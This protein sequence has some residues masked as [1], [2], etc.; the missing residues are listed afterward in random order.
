MILPEAASGLNTRATRTSIN[1]DLPQRLV[2]L[3]MFRKVEILTA[4]LAD[5][6]AAVEAACAEALA[7]GVCSADVVLNILNRRR[8]PSETAPIPT[9]ANLR[10]RFEPVAD[11][12]RYDRLRG[13]GHG[14]P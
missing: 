9:P 7:G 6:L 12:T 1:R 13:V 10:L 14:A 2:A 8:Q 5:G 3:V 11:C 4:V